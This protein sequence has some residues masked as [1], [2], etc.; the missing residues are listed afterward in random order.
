MNCSPGTIDALEPAPE[1]VRASRDEIELAMTGAVDH[2]G[3]QWA[4]EH[5]VSPILCKRSSAA[6][7]IGA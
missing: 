6:L 5:V 2:V 3:R 4:L 1:F 7:S